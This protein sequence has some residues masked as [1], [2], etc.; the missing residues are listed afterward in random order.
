MPVHRLPGNKRSAVYADPGELEAWLK[1]GGATRARADGTPSP[2]AAEAS[3]IAAAAP[4]SWLRQ[5]PVLAIAVV[6]A[7]LVGAIALW[8]VSAFRPTST[9]AAYIPVPEAEEFYV[10]GVYLWEKRTPES[11]REAA[12][13]L[14]RAVEVDPKYPRAYAA[15]ANTY[16]LLREYSVMPAAEAYAAAVEAGRKAVALDP[17]DADALSALAFAEFYGLRDITTGLARFETAREIDPSN[18]KVHHWLA[19]ALLHL[20]RF[21]DALIEINEAQRLDPTSRAI[22]SSKGLALFLVGRGDEAAALLTEMTRL[23]PDF[24]SPYAYLAYIYLARGEYAA[25]LDTLETAGTLREDTSRLLVARA[26]RQGLAAGGF[27]SM[28]EAMLAEERNQHQAGKTILYNVARLEALAGD[29]QGA[30]ET[31]QASVAAGEEYVMG[32]NIDPA[33]RLVRRTAAFREY[34]ATIGLPLI[35]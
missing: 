26:G 19:N 3:A 4:P 9:A 30:L 15:L 33:F 12:T 24:M 13:L 34:A 32:L 23:E 8:Q 7:L 21:D 27:D 29:A 14:H 17:K 18:P 5:Q 28:V 10:K 11:L 22:R 6:A 1:S 2:P 25:Y 31:L 20:G 35:Q 16:D